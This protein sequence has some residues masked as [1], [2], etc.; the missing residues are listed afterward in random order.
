MGAIEGYHIVGGLLGEV[1]DPLY[2]GGSFDPLGL[3]DDPVAFVKLKVKEIKNGHLTMF[4][5][6]G[7]FASL[8]PRGKGERA[9]EEEVVIERRNKWLWEC[10][11]L[12]KTSDFSFIH[13]TS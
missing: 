3:P 12:D 8:V 5:M 6:F 9:H 1:M 2:P 4:S 7:F 10:G 13:W 11:H